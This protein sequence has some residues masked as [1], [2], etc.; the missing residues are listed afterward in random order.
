MAA[1]FQAIAVDYD[2]T[3][4]RAD[5]PAPDVLA[6]IREQRER[7]RAVVLVTGRI[8]SELRRVFPEVEEEFDAIVAE[9][10]AVLADSDG[11]QE[12]A[13]P[14]DPAL[15]QRLARRDVPVRQGRVLLACDGH[16]DQAVIEEIVRLELGCQLVHNRA[17]LM[18]LPNGVTKGTGL[19]QALGNL[20]ISRHSTIAVGDAEND[21]HLLEV[22][23]LGI[24]V[25][26]AV[27]ALKRRA[28]VV[29]DASDGAGVAALL[30][31]PL[32]SGERWIAP[33]NWA[34]TLGHDDRGNEVQLPASQVNVLLVGASCSGKSYLVGSLVEQLVRLD[35]SVLVLDREGD[36]RSLADRRGIL[37]VGGRAPLPP[38]TQLADLLRHR[39][40]SVVVDLST[41]DADAEHDYVE[42]IAPVLLAQRA[43]TGLPHW[44][45]FD[46]AHELLADQA[47][48][49]EQLE[50]G[51][52]GYGCSSYRPDALPD[53]VER[54]C[55]LLVVTAGGTNGREEAQ[56]YAAEAAGCSQEELAALLGDHRG[57]AVLIDRADATPPRAFTVAERSS[58]HVRHWHKYI[59]GELPGPLRFYFAEADGGL[60][61]SNLREF[62]RH[63]G[64]CGVDSLEAHAR[65]HDLSRW[66]RDVLQ[67]E[68]LAAVI[69]DAEHELRTGR[70]PAEGFRDAARTAI[71]AQYLE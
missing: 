60:V 21:H 26:N 10:G 46:E 58:G 50:S 40:G 55:D 69:R 52:H 64:V 43:V 19:T 18:V 57:R 16:H 44:L 34:L 63:L 38:P 47:S 49:S 30:R 1:G 4:T 13:A 65:R 7:G 45:F 15:A 61:A 20:G 70:L 51:D 62:H 39:F 59:D 25:D 56:R 28:D 6:A 53:V 42:A 31:G 11:V 2:G 32:V 9:N 5:R 27:S 12:L 22:C 33:S 48:W 66:L 3:L 41:L 23:E 24:A 29:L 67:D 71:E 54:A 17:A 37:G 35:Y 8:L 14:V 36:H 68:D